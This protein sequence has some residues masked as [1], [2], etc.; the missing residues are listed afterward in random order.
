MVAGSDNVNDAPSRT[1]A[2][3]RHCSMY[4]RAFRCRCARAPR[5]MVSGSVYSIE[6]RPQADWLRLARSDGFTGRLRAVDCRQ[7]FR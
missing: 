4:P 1:A 5:E 2:S 7:F 6:D 3:S